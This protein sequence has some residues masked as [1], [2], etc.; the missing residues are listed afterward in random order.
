MARK[1]T[2]IVDKKDNNVEDPLK[3]LLKEIKEDIKS[4]D[5]FL[6]KLPP[7]FLKKIREDAIAEE[8][9]KARH[10]E[11][12]I[13]FDEIDREEEIEDIRIDD[14]SSNRV[15]DCY[16]LRSREDEID[17]D[18]DSEDENENEYFFREYEE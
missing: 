6:S 5:A 14:S 16:N 8:K 7:R 11:E 17:S 9:E 15:A 18:S 3:V 1:K 10:R 2:E 13:F 12:R 4:I